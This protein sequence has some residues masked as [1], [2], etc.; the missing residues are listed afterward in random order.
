MT[1]QAPEVVKEIGYG[2]F[3]NNSSLLKKKKI[4]TKADIW[5][6]GITILEMGEGRP[7]N[8]D[9]HPMRAIFMIPAKPSPTFAEPNSWGN[10]LRNFLAS[11][12]IKDPTQRP[13]SSQL[14]EVQFSKS[15]FLTKTKLEFFY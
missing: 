1:F 8:S 5:S 12:L 11:C 15:L 4:D 7:P 3:E 2:N 6:L 10:D 13:T 14:L 9:I